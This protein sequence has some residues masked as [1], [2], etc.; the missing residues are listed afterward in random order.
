MIVSLWFIFPR[1]HG[2]GPIDDDMSGWDPVEEKISAYEVL[3]NIYNILTLFPILW[4]I[5]CYVLLI[6]FLQGNKG[7]VLE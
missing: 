5:L 7:D 1:Q 3:K 6:G 2:C 4:L